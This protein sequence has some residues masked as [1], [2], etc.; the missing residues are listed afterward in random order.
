MLRCL[1]LL[2]TW[3]W[4]SRNALCANCAS[5]SNGATRWLH[6][7]LCLSLLVRKGRWWFL[8]SYNKGYLYDALS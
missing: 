6:R 2:S 7:C 5:G 3:R 8:A 4:M 1:S